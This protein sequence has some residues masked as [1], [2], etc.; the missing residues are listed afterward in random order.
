MKMKIEIESPL[1]T[2]KQAAKYLNI[3]IATL[4]RH[5]ELPRVKLFGNQV[6]FEKAELDKEIEKYRIPGKVKTQN[7]VRVGESVLC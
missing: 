2:R 3:S 7:S 6:M 1:L 5:S 4:D